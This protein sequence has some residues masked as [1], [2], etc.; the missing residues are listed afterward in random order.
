[1]KIDDRLYSLL[2]GVEI[3]VVFMYLIVAYKIIVK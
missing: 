1:M 3:G 2:L